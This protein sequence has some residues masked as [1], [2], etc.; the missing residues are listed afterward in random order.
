MDVVKTISDSS[1][2][3]ILKNALNLM[4]AVGYL[5]KPVSR[6][7]ADGLIRDAAKFLE[8]TKRYVK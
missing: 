8:W 7:E 2:R 1:C 6:G 5:G 3:G 4:S